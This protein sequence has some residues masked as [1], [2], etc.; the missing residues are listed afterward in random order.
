VDVKVNPNKPV[1]HDVVEKFLKYYSVNEGNYSVPDDY[2]P[3]Q[4]I[5]SLDA[6]HA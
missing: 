3:H 4:H 1:R 5:I 6:T 2:A